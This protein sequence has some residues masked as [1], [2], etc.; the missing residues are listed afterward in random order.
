MISSAKF[1][2]VLELKISLCKLQVHK[3]LKIL[4]G[5][6]SLSQKSNFH[7]IKI[8]LKLFFYFIQY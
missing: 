4:P 6:C 5:F 8:T 7:N 2:T 1:G 3:K